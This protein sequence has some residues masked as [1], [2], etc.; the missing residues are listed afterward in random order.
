MTPT[1]QDN[2]LTKGISR[3]MYKLV[4]DHEGSIGT[5]TGHNALIAAHITDFL[6]LITAD[7]KRVALEAAIMGAKFGNAAIRQYNIA[8]PTKPIN[9]DVVR[10]SGIQQAKA[11]AE[12]QCWAG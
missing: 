11:W 9:L 10:D 8:D 2:E 1:E 12:Q 5:T 3:L 4:E 6:Q 7:R